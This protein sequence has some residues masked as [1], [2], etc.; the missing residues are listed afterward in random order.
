MTKTDRPQIKEIVVVEGLHDKQAVE[1]AVHAEVWVLGGDRLASHL[2]A[3]L[4]RAA[5]WRGVLIF[6]DPDGPGERIRARLTVAI[7][8]CQHAFLPRSSARS[9]DGTRIG[10]EFASVEDIRAALL[11]ARVPT[12]NEASERE[13][14]LADLQT[15]G[16][17]NHPQ[18]ALRR[19]VMGQLLR[20]GYA[21]AKSFLR[22][23]NTLGVTRQEWE[24]ATEGLRS[25][26]HRRE[27]EKGK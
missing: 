5:A 6:T 18:A 11:H 4:K 27:S 26:M 20:I 2:L 22:K 3:E 8:T 21:N 25:E 12:A 14:S 1:N 23:L 10:V 24:H 17:I 13:F 16:L 19:T 9:R 7:P 15:T